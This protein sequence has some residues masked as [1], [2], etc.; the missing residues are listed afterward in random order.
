MINWS[1]SEYFKFYSPL[2]IMLMCAQSLLIELGFLGGLS[3]FGYL[4]GSV[5]GADFHSN[6]NL[7]LGQV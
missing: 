1:Y 5:A 2:N 6:Q 7:E 4:A 3:G